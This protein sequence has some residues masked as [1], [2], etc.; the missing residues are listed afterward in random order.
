MA[1]PRPSVG[2]ATWPRCAG[3]TTRCSSAF[4]PLYYS[5]LP[6]GDVDDRKLDDIYAVAVAHLALGRVRAPGEPVVRVL[7]PDRERDGW[8]SEH[9]VAARRHRRHAVP[10]RHDADGPRAP[11]PRHPPARPPDAGRR[12]ATTDATASSTSPP[13]VGRRRRRLVEAWTQ[14]EIDRTDEATAPEL[15]AEIAAAVERRAAGSST[16]SPRCATGWRR[17]AASTRSCRGWPTASSCSSAPPTTTSR[18]RRRRR[19]ARAASSGWPATTRVRRRRGRCPA[20]GAGRRSPAPTTCRGCSGPSA[21]RWSPCARRRRAD[22]ETRFVGLLA[23][24]A[25]RVSV[26]DIPG[27]GA[28]VA[29]AP[30]PRPRRGCTRHTGRATRNVLENL[31]RDLVLELEPTAVAAARRPPSSGCRS[32]SWCGC[33]R[34]PSPSGRGSTVLVYLPA[35]RFTAE[36]P[37]AGR[38]RRRRRLRRRPSARSSRTSAPARWPASRSACAGPSGAGAVDLD[39]LERLDRRAVDVVGRPAAR[40][41]SSPSVGEEQAPRR[42]SSAVGAHA[43][44]VVP[45]R[46]R[47]RTRADRRR[48][49]HRRAAR[50]RRRADDVARPRRRRRRRA[51]GGSASTGAATPAALSE[52]LPLLDHLGLQALDERPYTFRARRRAG[53]RLRH[54]RAR[55]A[56]ASSSTTPR[57]AELQDAFAALV[58]GD[59]RERRLQPARAAGRADRRARSTVLRAYGKYLRQI[60]FAFSQPYIEDDAAPPPAPRR[61]PRRAV[62]RPLRPGDFGGVDRRR[63]AP[64]PPTCERASSRRS[65]PSRAS[66][67]TASA[68]PS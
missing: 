56:P 61:R 29:D 26:L 25:Y 63:P 21:R 49:A 4:L 67:T 13:D 50:R 39:A 11:R 35:A 8:H 31:P 66:T 32:A 53:V 54:R 42:C 65:T 23:T 62:P 3:P 33:S 27:V 41:R 12:S 24:N 30:R 40:A 46:R 2:C 19:C 57:T 60:G 59:G 47:R 18:R 44:G 9:S 43:P 45:R 16:T 15:E 37:G 38:R 36:L 22:T 10:R 55:A 14:I 20:T 52:L 68:G 51:S 7:S 6:E 1:S 64:R 5:E 17:S 28:A 58:A 48:P 34:C